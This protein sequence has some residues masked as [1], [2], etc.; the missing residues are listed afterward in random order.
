[1][2]TRREKML[3]SNERLSDEEIK[4]LANLS[5]KA[6]KMSINELKLTENDIQSLRIVLELDPLSFFDKEEFCLPCFSRKVRDFLNLPRLKREKL[7]ERLTKRQN[8]LAK[9]M[10]GYVYIEGKNTGLTFD[11]VLE[12]QEECIRKH[13]EY[14]EVISKIIKSYKT[15]YI[16]PSL[17]TLPY[18][19]FGLNWI[20]AEVLFESG[21]KQYLSHTVADTSQTPCVMDKIA[22][23]V[24]DDEVVVFGGLQPVIRHES[25][26]D[27]QTGWRQMVFPQIDIKTVSYKPDDQLQ[28]TIDLLSITHIVESLRSLGFA[29]NNIVIHINDH[30][31]IL[32][33]LLER[34]GLNIIEIR[35]F[36]FLFNEMTT[37][38][39]NGSEEQD[40]ILRQKIIAKL[41]KYKNKVRID[42]NVVAFI[43]EVVE[44]KRYN[45]RHIK[46]KHKEVTNR[47][48][49]LKANFEILN[50]LYIDSEIK[51]DILPTIF[52]NEIDSFLG[53][54]ADIKISEQEIYREVASIASNMSSLRRDGY[55]LGST[56]IGIL[57]I[58]KILNLHGI[59]PRALS[60]M[61]FERVKQAVSE[62]RES[63][64][65]RTIA[66][67]I[68]F[69]K[70]YPGLLNA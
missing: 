39:L 13:N 60:I 38:Y 29:D 17:R 57:R 45:T 7:Y 30:W 3:I 37:Y 1:M 6:L 34:V 35:H 8:Q 68:P 53:G 24:S 47:V 59:E 18:D 26:V 33:R 19:Q 65:E 55:Y 49:R 52:I 46:R 43:K 67:L 25:Q 11:R 28:Q 40:L 23:M 15:H 16:V 32:G 20:T 9:Q 31:G 51:F 5:V 70:V 48:N 56:T 21:K 22:K 66:Q 10:P 69:Q 14:F 58:A 42:N 44:Y 62:Y 54:Q 41:Q 4:S 12:L 27:I 50:Q 63:V 36:R 64:D 2:S 61:P